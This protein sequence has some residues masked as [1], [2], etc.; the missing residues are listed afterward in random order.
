[1]GDIFRKLMVVAAMALFLAGCADESLG[2]EYGEIGEEE[3]GLQFYAPGLEGGYRKFIYGQ[4]E[5][6]VKQT[7]GV[8]GPKQGEFPHGQ[9]IL[10]EMPPRMYFPN[11][12]LPQDTIKDWGQFKNRTITHGPAGAAVNRV[13]RVEYAI[14]LADKL[15]C[16][17]FRQPFGTVY[18]SG[19]GGT[20]LIGGY[21]CKGEAPMMTEGEA[22]AIV[23]AVGHK[24][25]GAIEPPEGWN[26]TAVS[27]T[28]ELLK[29]GNYVAESSQVVDADT[30]SG[31]LTK[32]TNVKFV[33]QTDRVSNA[34]NTSFGI[35]YVL[36]GP[37]QGEEVVVTMRI[38]HPKIKGNT[39][40]TWISRPTTGAPAHLGYGFDFEYERVPGTWTFQIIYGE[41]ILIEKSFEVVV[42][43]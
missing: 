2:P 11:V 9:L 29:F 19:G 31:K 22:V 3:S 12:T 8:Y 7:V 26:T 5:R 23:K 1:M 6:Y 33:S 21:Y 13:G 30:P 28:G 16:I 41:Q 34:L 24:K 20:R 15:S 39:V 14:F 27:L 17:V 42:S 40:K 18:G 10:V 43:N 4:D 35:Q 32:S 38:L 36:N 25:Y 37:R